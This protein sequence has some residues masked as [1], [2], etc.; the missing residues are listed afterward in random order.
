MDFQLLFS[1]IQV[2]L[3][4]I[5]LMVVVNLYLVFRLKEIDPFAKWNPSLLNGGGFF[6]FYII[7]MVAA[8]VST[9]YYYPELTLIV[10]P[11]SEHGVEID[12]MFN[13]TMIVTILVVVVT[14]FVLFY[15]S[16][17][18]RTKPGRKALYYPHN[19]R[20]EVIWTVVP[21]IVLTVLVFDGV[22]VWHDIMSDPPEDA[23]QIEVNGKQFSWTY[24][25]AGA[26]QEFGESNVTF[27]N[28]GKGNELGINL[29]DKRGYDDLV[30]R[31][32]HLPVGVPVNLN[33]RTRDVLHSATLAH[34]RVKMDAVSGITT[35]FHFVPT[36]TTR[37]WR[38]RTGDPEFNF[39]MS[40][41]Q[42]C[43]GGHWNMGAKVVVETMEEYQDWLSSQ[44]TFLATYQGTNPDFKPDQNMA[45]ESEEGTEKI[46]DAGL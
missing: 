36:I 40:C 3:G 5:F 32:L 25:Y 39:Q 4:L 45:S 26:D 21:A 11:A 27:I 34:F 2:L 10:N 30:T 24:R 28:E 44:Q 33:I 12:R 37:E 8:T 43:G 19:N 1:S 23:I 18:Y 15:Y 13:N 7:G 22:G 16:F 46:A 38:E 20:L 42:I 14:N 31:E 17:R 29:D 41:Q 35:N 6:A 9:I